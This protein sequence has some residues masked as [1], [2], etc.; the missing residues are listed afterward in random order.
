MLKSVEVLI[1]VHRYSGGGSGRALSVSPLPGLRASSG[2]AQLRLSPFPWVTLGTGSQAVLWGGHGQGWPHSPSHRSCFG[3]MLECFGRS[4]SSSSSVLQLCLCLAM[5]TVDPE[6][7]ADL[8]PAF[9]GRQAM[10]IAGLCLTL[11]TVTRPDPNP[12]L[13]MHIPGLTSDLPHHPWTLMVIWPLPLSWPALG[14]PG[15][16]RG[17]GGCPASLAPHPSGCS[18]PTLFPDKIWLLG[19]FLLMPLGCFSPASSFTLCRNFSFMLLL[20]GW[21]W[22]LKAKLFCWQIPQLN[23]VF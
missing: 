21:I 9:P 10:E 2:T 15:R 17:T 12:N 4:L 11:G 16:Y 3:L 5:D 13:L 14:L 7:D 6:P 23:L 1:L 20:M 19:I 22:E 18:R 8:P